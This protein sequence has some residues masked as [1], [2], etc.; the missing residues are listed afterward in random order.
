MPKRT[1]KDIAVTARE[2]IERLRAELAAIDVV[3]SGTLLKRMKTCG[4]PGCRC[5]TDPDARHGPYYE[6]GH[7]KAGKL[8][9]RLVSPAQA[10]ALRLSIANYRKIKRLLRAWEAETERLI[11]AEH[12]RSS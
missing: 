9:H 10:E 7:M 2:R 6:W 8:L 4:S 5:A 3:C 11:D 1:P 12:P